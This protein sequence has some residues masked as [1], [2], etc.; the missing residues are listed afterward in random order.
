MNLQETSIFE[1]ENSALRRDSSELDELLARKVD[2]GHLNQQPPMGGPSQTL[3]GRLAGFTESGLPLVKFA[4]NPNE[5]AI[6]ARSVCPLGRKDM[7][8]EAV[9]VLENG[10]S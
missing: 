7:G 9:I 10:N 4:A 5:E 6:P 1:M 3:I 8:R 2:A